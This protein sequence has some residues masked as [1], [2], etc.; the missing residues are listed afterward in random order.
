MLKNSF[1]IYYALLLTLLLNNASFAQKYIKGNFVEP[2]SNIATTNLLPN[3]SR[4][5]H[6]VAYTKLKAILPSTD[7]KNASELIGEF[8]LIDGMLINVISR[9]ISPNVLKLDL[10]AVNYGL[11]PKINKMK[12]T[13]VDMTRVNDYFYEI[14][15]VKNADVL[16]SYF[17]TFPTRKTFIIQDK[18][19]KYTVLGSIYAIK[20]DYTKAHNYINTL[21]NS[22]TFK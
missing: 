10:N 13:T 4:I 1:K 15:V 9:K 22:I 12:G 2:L 14:K 6:S 16:I 11:S 21:I 17:K 18:L 3:S 20:S 8:W 19:G 5:D 7:Y